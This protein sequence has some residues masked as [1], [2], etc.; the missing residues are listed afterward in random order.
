MDT[1][2]S[3]PNLSQALS[4]LRNL[5]PCIDIKR[6]LVYL[7]YTASHNNVPSH[8]PPAERVAWI[9]PP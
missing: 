3:G 7:I 9:F 1:I 4:R 6:W 2:G 5:F 8:R